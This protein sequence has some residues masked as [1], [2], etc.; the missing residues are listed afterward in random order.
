MK[1]DTRT[2]RWLGAAFVAQFI[3]SVAA[4]VLSAKVVAAGASGAL[5]AATGNLTMVRAAGLM[6]L[7][8]GAGIAALTALLF[9]ALG[10]LDRPRALA[11]GALWLAEVAMLAASG[12]GLY[13][14]AALGAQVAGGAATPSLAAAATLAFSLYQDAFT[15]SMLFFC[16]GA[17]LWYSLL[18]QSELVPH[19]LAGWGF[20]TVLPLL[21]SILLTLWDRGL[22]LGV[23]PGLP[24]APFELVVGIWLI[25]TAGRSAS[26]RSASAHDG[27]TPARLGGAL[28]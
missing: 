7:L 12:L 21:V 1:S 14:L 16:L 20:V 28:S 27:A 6:E 15:A 9:A 2:T 10:D 11:A 25:V 4:A 26:S 18:Y 23:L 24:Y 5:P 19:W 17:L 8:T 3:T 22:S 13:A